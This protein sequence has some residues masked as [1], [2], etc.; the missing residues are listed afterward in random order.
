MSDS[1]RQILDAFIDNIWIE[2]GLS[3]NTLDSYRS[4]L[5]QFS[6]WLKKN[7]LSFWGTTQI[8]PEYQSITILPNDFKKI[9]NKLYHN[10]FYSSLS[11]YFLN[12]LAVTNIPAFI[13]RKLVKHIKFS[14]SPDSSF[15]QNADS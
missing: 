15:S 12:I 1:D 14:S 7:N 4:D 11:R 5:E 8:N 10:F 13:K 6:K 2:K 3:Q 9:I